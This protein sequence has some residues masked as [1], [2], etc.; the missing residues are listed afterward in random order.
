MVPH[1]P[2]VEIAFIHQAEGSGPLFRLFLAG[3]SGRI[4]SIHCL[5]MLSEADAQPFCI[6]LSLCLGHTPLGITEDEEKLKIIGA[7]LTALVL[8]PTLLFFAYDM[9]V[10][11][12]RRADLLVMKP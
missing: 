9:F 7:M 1:L 4:Y 6:Q 2:Y 3:L 10:Y 12:A 8:G 11:Q 5:K